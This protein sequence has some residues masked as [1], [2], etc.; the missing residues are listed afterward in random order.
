VERRARGQVSPARPDELWAGL[1][2]DACAAP[3]RAEGASVEAIRRE[4]HEVIAR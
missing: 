3:A 2:E 4:A 1:T